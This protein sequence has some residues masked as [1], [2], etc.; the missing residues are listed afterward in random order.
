MSRRCAWARSSSVTPTWKETSRSEMVI[1]SVVSMDSFFPACQ[2]LFPGRGAAG[3]DGFQQ[4]SSRL[5]QRK[6]EGFRRRQPLELLRLLVQP[7]VRR[8]RATAGGV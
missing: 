1:L 2:P 8:A 6:L 7:H 5:I 4:D 3:R